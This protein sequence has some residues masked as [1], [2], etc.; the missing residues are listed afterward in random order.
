MPLPVICRQCPNVWFVDN[1]FGGTSSALMLGNECGPCPKCGGMGA[2]P[3]CQYA[4]VRIDYFRDDQFERVVKA[5]EDIQAKAVAGASL[6]ELSDEMLNNPVLE[7]LKGY[8]PTNW[9]EMEH[10]L[11]CF[12]LIIGAIYAMRALG[13]ASVS[14]PQDSEKTIRL[15][16]SQSP[17]LHVD[18]QDEIPDSQTKT[19]VRV[20]LQ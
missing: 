11:K 5:L 20:N 17:G 16:V 8:I 1:I 3:D 15:I 12:A 9:A 14:V 7:F 2:I 19:E 18:V 10:M 4:E 6:E 13:S